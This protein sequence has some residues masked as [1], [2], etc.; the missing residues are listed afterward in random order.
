MCW[1]IKS[2]TATASASDKPE[3]P[4]TRRGSSLSCERVD[5]MSASACPGDKFSDALNLTS[6]FFGLLYQRFIRATEFT[7][8]RTR[9]NVFAHL[10]WPKCLSEYVIKLQIDAGKKAAV[11][12][13]II[14]FWDSLRVIR[15]SILQLLKRVKSVFLLMQNAAQCCHLKL[16]VR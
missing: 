8:A 6:T 2:A 3:F 13:N 11:E 15:C 7:L 9:W 4:E 12:R 5:S 1:G 14:F 16:F 10:H